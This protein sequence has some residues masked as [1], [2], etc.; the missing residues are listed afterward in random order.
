MKFNIDK[1]IFEKYPDLKVGLIIIKGIENNRRISPVES[2][3]RGITAQRAREFVAKD[4]DAEKM[5]KIWNQAYSIFEINAK[6]DSPELRSL[7]YLAQLKK[8]IPHTSPIVDIAYYHILKYLLP[9]RKFDLDWLCGDLNLGYTSGGEPFREINSIEVSEAEKGEVAYMDEGGIVSKH[10]NSKECERAKIIDKTSNVAFF[11]EDLSIMASDQFS[12]ILTEIASTIQKYIGGDI[13]INLLNDENMSAD[14]GVEG[15]KNVDDSKISAQEK[16]YYMVKK[17]DE[18]RKSITKKLDII[19]AK[20]NKEIQEEKKQDKENPHAIIKKQN[21]YSEKIEMNDKDSLEEKIKT[22]VEQGIVKAF[23]KPIAAS[24]KIEYPTQKEHGDYSCN[25]AMQL[26]KDLSASPREIAEKLSEHISKEDFIEKIEIAG[27]G[28]LNFF[29]SKNYLVKEI[30]K[31]LEEKENYGKSTVGD[32]KTVLVEYS[33]PNIAKPLGVHHLIGTILG[34]SL[35]NIY[36]FT[37]FSAV[38]INYLG[39]WGTQ[40]GKLIYAYKRWGKKSEIELSP[41]KELLKLYVKFHDEAEKRSEIEDD[42]RREFKIFEEGDRENRKI[43]KWIVEESV[44]ELNKTYDKLG[45]IKF[46]QMEGESDYSDKLEEILLDGKQR[47]IFEQG[48]EGA[49][50]IKYDDPNIPPYLVQKKDSTTLYSTRDFAALKERINK[51]R[52]L[53]ILYVV[54]IAQTLHFKQLFEGSKRFSWYH[55]EAVHVWYGRMSFKDKKL[56]TRKG[57]VILL[58]EVIDEAI[59]RAKDVIKEKNPNIQNI[60]NIAKV[61]GI[62][63]IKYSILSQNR[64]TNITFDW[65]KMLSL[66]GNSSPYLQ[67]TYARAKSILRKVDQDVQ[68]TSVD[69]ELVQEKIDNLMRIIPKFKEHILSSA[70]EYKPNI[71]CTYLFTLSQ[72]FNTFYNT[73]PVLKAEK[74]EDKE[75]RIALVEVTSQILKNGLSLLGI[76]VVE[77]M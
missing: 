28:F 73:V 4:I 35:N 6:K 27:P 31:A 16:A 21:Q 47:G 11:I 29:I 18:E 44:K 71:L 52:P 65:D 57:N 43:W 42:A 39:D 70:R 54:D 72:E 53:K 76:D 40:F 1:E 63:A 8:E 67:Y 5:I 32:G 2:L 13:T 34:Q 50:I 46:D 45:N 36:K 26:A 25:I 49:Y 22:A 55:G 19:S 9:I 69:S 3:L 7:L 60:E 30:N 20:T 68:G 66:D 77:E 12:K 14:L 48:E 61:I 33:S 38:G 58:D 23:S 41:I 59:S 64:T 62:G 17:K 10:W 51:Y 74:E 37:G 24:V 56:S 75:A 15:R